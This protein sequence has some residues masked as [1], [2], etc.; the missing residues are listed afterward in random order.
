MT[1]PNDAASAQEAGDH[2]KPVAVSQGRV[3]ELLQHGAIERQHGL[4]G[5]GS[6]HAFL[7]TVSDGSLEVLAVYKPQ[8]GERPLW[9][10]PDGT[11]CRRE[12]AAY[13]LSE[14][15]GW[16]LVP[17]TVLREGP[18][19]LGSLQFFVHH[20]P[21]VNYFSLSKAMSESVAY[22]LMQF[23][24][25]DVVVNNADRKGG[26]FLLGEDG[27]LWGI[28]H[29]LTF[30]VTSKLRTVVWDFAGKAIPAPIL[31]D[32]ENLCAQ[33][34]AGAGLRCALETLLSRQEVDMTQVRVR[35]LLSHK[36]Y[37]QP[38]PGPNY[39]WPPV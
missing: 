6:N 32:L 7:V 26:H 34:E 4:L 37:P 3:L 14:A 25:F 39:P 2:D 35:R 27:H 11:L 9:D 21:A 31:A 19:G 5:W 20:D 8:P 17:P 24:A 1:T 16:Q 30:N 13:L 12:V 15:L 29:G 18:I 36:R 33:L 10:F 22:R 28:D 38:G 23:A